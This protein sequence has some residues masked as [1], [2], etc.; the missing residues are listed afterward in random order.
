MS[1]CTP[2]GLEIKLS[3]PYTFTLMHR[4]YPAVDAFKV[5]KLPEGLQSIPSCLAFV[6]TLVCFN[7]TVAPFQTLVFVFRAAVLGTL[8][9]LWAFVVPG[10]PSVGKLYS[11][12]SGVGIL[13]VGLVIYGFVAVGFWGVLACSAGR[14]AAAFVSWIVELWNGQRLYR[15]TG[16]RLG[17][18]ELN[19]LWAYELYASETIAS[20]PIS[21]QEF[22]RSLNTS[23]TQDQMK[24]E[25]WKPC[26]MDLARRWPKVV[27]RF[28]EPD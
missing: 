19:F 22:R 9:A 26:F 1:I 28:R 24:V 23:L 12:V 6:T 17:L 2:R 20:P 14:L 5:L 27:A 4:L 25:N 10:L 13:F 21:F 8:L 16:V 11:Y 7:L 3:V 18:P 15:R